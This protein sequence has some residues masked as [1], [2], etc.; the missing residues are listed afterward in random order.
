MRRRKMNLGPI[1]V[2]T[3][4]SNAVDVFHPV[5]GPL[6]MSELNTIAVAW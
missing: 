2:W 6:T 3:A 1:I 5:S 4:R